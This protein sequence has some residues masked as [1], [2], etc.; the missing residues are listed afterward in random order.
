[1]ILLSCDAHYNQDLMFSRY[2]YMKRKF[3]F[4]DV[5]SDFG[6]WSFHDG[7]NE[8]TCCQLVVQNLVPDVSELVKNCWNCHSQFVSCF[9]LELFWPPWHLV[10][11][12][13]LLLTIFLGVD[14]LR[15]SD[16]RWWR[17]FGKKR[18]WGNQGINYSSATSLTHT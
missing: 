1:M 15:R 9:C 10:K 18:R 2:I 3:C 11:V 6:V 8:R 16:Q 4:H 12:K 14:N 17:I 7:G 13:I 5:V